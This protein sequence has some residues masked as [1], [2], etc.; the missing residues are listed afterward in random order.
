METSNVEFVV[1]LP[2]PNIVQDDTWLDSKHKNVETETLT[3]ESVHQSACGS[4]PES[5]PGSLEETAVTIQAESPPSTIKL[6]DVLESVGL[7]DFEN[8]FVS[9]HID[10]EM[11]LDLGDEELMDMFRSILE[12]SKI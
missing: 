1:Q 9:E 12:S 3:A 8:V 11:L 2:N 4:Q 10:M 5:V 7:E 6:G